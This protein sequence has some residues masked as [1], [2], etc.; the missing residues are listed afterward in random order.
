VADPEVAGRYSISFETHHGFAGAF[1]DSYV[2]EPPIN[3]FFSATFDSTVASGL[4][5]VYFQAYQL[6]G[7][8]SSVP[9][10]TFP[11]HLVLDRIQTSGPQQL[12]LYGVAAPA[13]VPRTPTTGDYTGTITLDAF[14][15]PVPEPQTWLLVAAGLLMLCTRA[16]AARRRLPRTLSSDARIVE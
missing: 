6:N 8:L 7:E 3:G 1:A 2:F 4:E 9:A 15:V 11:E 16:A 12:T 13:L 5:G 14:I 10:G